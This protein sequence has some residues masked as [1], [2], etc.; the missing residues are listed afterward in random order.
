MS[1]AK[2]IVALKIGRAKYKVRY[3]RLLPALLG[4]IFFSTRSIVADDSQDGAELADTLLHEAMHGI[5]NQRKLGPR[6]REERAVTELS[7]GLVCLFRDNPGFL[8]HLESLI[9]EAR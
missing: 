9:K 2:P 6:V 8:V 5:W 3:R 4:R 7:S 1:D